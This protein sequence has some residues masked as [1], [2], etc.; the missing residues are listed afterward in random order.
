M[1]DLYDI[2]LIFVLISAL[3]LLFTLTAIFVIPTTFWQWTAAKVEVLLHNV[4]IILRD[5]LERSNANILPAQAA[6]LAQTDLTANQTTRNDAARGVVQLQQ[7]NNNN[8]HNNLGE[9]L[10]VPVRATQRRVPR[11]KIV[12]RAR[13]TEMK[14]ELDMINGVLVKTITPVTMD[15]ETVHQKY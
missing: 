7:T 14:T 6:Q 8:N 15:V 11:E 13:K 5:R 2:F 9:F 12:T 4:I 1:F 3:F 10:T